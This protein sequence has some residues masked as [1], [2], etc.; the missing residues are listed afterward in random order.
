M[1][2][3]RS[4][5]KK[6]AL[7]ISVFTIPRELFPYAPSN[8]K[9]KKPVVISTWRHGVAANEAA[10]KTLQAGGS[11][12]DAVE[13]GVNVSEDDPNV[14]SVGYGGLPDE[15]GRVTLDACIMN[16][17]YESGAVAF[18][19]NYKNP[20]SI[21]R[22]V[23]EETNHIFIAGQGAEEFAEKMGFQKQ[24]LLTENAKQV[25]LKWKAE[26]PHGANWKA[27]PDPHNH[28]TISMLALDNEGRLSGACTTSGLAWKMHGRVGDS[29][30]IGAGMYCDGEIGAA[31][32]TGKGEAVI[33]I[34][35]SFL[36]VEFMRHGMSP[37]KACEEA[38]KR[39]L[40]ANPDKPQ[41]GFIALNTKGE[42]GAYAVKS[43][44]QYA[45]YREGK[46]TLIDAGHVI[47][48]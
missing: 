3:R 17:K 14:T 37:Q 44:F 22:K 36:V 20:I 19:Q 42:V 47:K 18:V 38:V 39:L 45:L 27:Y 25:W 41:V 12:L 5:I 33:K 13:K 26:H 4:F 16:W 24:N 23:M 40:K 46:N 10:W 35:G 1:S 7:G 8:E 48:G 9:G 15:T 43:K 29:P 6:S 31:G 2:T 34:C 30:I 11:A 21:A 32:A 28:D